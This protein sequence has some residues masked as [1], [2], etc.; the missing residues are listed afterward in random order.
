MF[1]GGGWKRTLRNFNPKFTLE[2]RVSLS[3][4]ILLVMKGGGWGMVYF[5]LWYFFRTR[6]WSINRKTY[7]Y[8]L[9]EENWC[10]NLIFFSPFSSDCLIYICFCVTRSSG[11]RRTWQVTTTSQQCPSPL[12]STPPPWTKC[13]LIWQMSGKAQ[14]STVGST[15]LKRCILADKKIQWCNCN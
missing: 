11:M 5:S 8:L 6:F 14:S 15:I 13:H 12:S 7:V 2:W 10:I 9:A 1:G 3:W 4:A